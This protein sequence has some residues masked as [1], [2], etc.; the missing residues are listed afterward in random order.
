MQR[1]RAS[2]LN[3]FVVRDVVAFLHPDDNDSVLSSKEPCKLALG[4]INV[5][6][7]G[8]KIGTVV[9]EELFKSDLGEHVW[10]SNGKCHQ[11]PQSSVMRVV[12]AK[13]SQRVDADRVKNT[14]ANA[15]EV[16][17]VFEETLHPW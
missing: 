12:E 16:W 15:E 14:H 4:R 13:Y 6:H 7:H 10:L 17:E 8:G 11:I 2:S 5:I 9:V 1:H 3:L